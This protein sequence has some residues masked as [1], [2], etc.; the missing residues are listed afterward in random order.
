MVEIPAVKVWT[1]A[2]GV[3]Y[4]FFQLRKIGLASANSH[5]P[6]VIVSAVGNRKQ[7][8]VHRGVLLRVERWYALIP[9]HGY[10]G[11]MKNGIH[12]SF[13][14]RVYAGDL[15]QGS[16]KDHSRINREVP[17]PLNVRLHGSSSTE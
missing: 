6:I 10:E 3:R 12:K 14:W 7:S 9:A 8:S 1:R 16:F 5:F 4:L 17:W 15:N 2:P 13:T 11:S